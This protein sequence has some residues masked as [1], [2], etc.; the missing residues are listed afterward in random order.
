MLNYLKAIAV[1][2]V[3]LSATARAEVTIPEQPAYPLPPDVQQSLKTLA[4]ECDV[5][6]IG[7]THGTKEVP[8]I[9]EGS[10][11]TLTK[12][13]YR[14]LALEVP[15]D[16]QQA[17]TAWAKGD[18][19]TLPRFFEKPSEDGRGNQQVLALLRRALK[20]PF[21]W[22]LICFDSTEE[23]FMRQI[24]ERIPKTAT[25]SIADRAAKISP[26]DIVA[27]S[28]QRDATMAKN[29]A[30]EREKLP[31]KD[32][33]LTIGGNVHAR[34]A[35]H[36]PAKSQK[37]ALWPSFAALLK[38]EHPQWQVR[39]INVEAF[40]GEYFNGGKVNKFAER[41]LTKVEARPTA[42]ADWDWELNLPHASAA[43][44]LDRPNN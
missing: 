23:E 44:F 14:A 1:A 39:S 6:V 18:T 2:F 30:A 24:M 5:L 27:I 37:T 15:R 10:L 19:A 7:E 43:T 4:S 35:N 28:L 26:D 13:G 16:Q 40:G 29:F 8:A 34:T 21:E 20:P 32:K 22:K 25:G 11:D 12:L 36:A 9:V 33:V 31:K 38:R 17:V 41:P 3:V 42:E